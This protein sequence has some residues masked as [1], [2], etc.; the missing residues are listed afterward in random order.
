MMLTSIKTVNYKYLIVL[1]YILCNLENA[2]IN[3]TFSP[4]VK[5]LKFAYNVSDFD[6]YYLSICYSIFYLFMNF[7]ANYIIE[8]R[9]IKS[10]LLIF[11]IGQVICCIFRLFINESISYVYIGQ[12]ISA[13]SCPFCN[14]VVSKISLNWFESKQRI[15]STSFMTSSYMLGSGF[16]FILSTFFVE[17]PVINPD[18]SLQKNQI[19]AYMASG[20]FLSIGI[21]IMVFFFFIEKPENPCCLVADYPRESYFES[22]KLIIRNKNFVYL[23]SGFALQTSNFCLFVVYTHFILTPFGFSETQIAYIGSLVNFWC[24]FGK[25]VIGYLVYR[26]FSFKKS[27]FYICLSLLVSILGFLLSLISGSSAL[28]FIFSCFF[29]FFLQMYW[30]PSYEFACELIFPVGEANANGGLILCGC[31]INI[32]FGFIFSI[33]FSLNERIW[34]PFTFSYFLISTAISLVLFRNTKEDLNREKKEFELNAK[35]N[36][37]PLLEY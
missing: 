25:L 16:T 33:I 17:D 32:V 36:S 5:S 28:I 21:L 1:I 2:F 3:F 22:L 11:A 12:T 30:S 4:I 8:H 37:F 13:L 6:I 23:C 31:L 15:I 7:P 10:S 14:N 24:F 29:G 27:L 20:F 18:I 9:G 19:L 26:V 35:T 34:V